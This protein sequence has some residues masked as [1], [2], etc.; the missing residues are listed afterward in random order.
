MKK[1]VHEACMKIKTL[2]VREERNGERLGKI[3]TGERNVRR[4]HHLALLEDGHA[5]Q[6]HRSAARRIV[7]SGERKKSMG[8]LFRGGLK[9]RNEGARK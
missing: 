6:V 9:G 5:A 7:K 2:E 4:D 3:G 8:V 1:N